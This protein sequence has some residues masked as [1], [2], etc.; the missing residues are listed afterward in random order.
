MLARVFPNVDLKQYHV[1]QL[2]EYLDSLQY[3]S[4]A[5]D[6]TFH[7]EQQLTM[8]TNNVHGFA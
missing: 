5:H 8:F 7:I 6:L 4:G 2:I 3:G 1:E